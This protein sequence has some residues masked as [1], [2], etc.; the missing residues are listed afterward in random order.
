MSE[1]PITRKHLSTDELAAAKALELPEVELTDE[2]ADLFR[3]KSA[4]RSRISDNA[5]QYNALVRKSIDTNGLVGVEILAKNADAV[6]RII[7]SAASAIHTD[8]GVPFTANIRRKTSSKRNH[9][10]LVISVVPR[11][12]R[13]NS[14]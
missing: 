9:V 12:I 4:G 1:Q 8:E 6:E 3:R 2:D 10:I 14:N 7:K 5:E 11:K 13:Q